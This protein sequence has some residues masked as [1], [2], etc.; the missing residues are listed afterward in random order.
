MFESKSQ[1]T[2]DT[3]YLLYRCVSKVIR[4]M[5]ESK[6]QPSVWWHL[7]RQSCVSKVIRAMFE[8]KSQL[9]CFGIIQL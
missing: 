3:Q 5:F 4:A 8:S 2:F 6:S 7:Q 1:P 9:R